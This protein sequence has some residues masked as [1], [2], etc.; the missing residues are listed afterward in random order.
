MKTDGFRAFVRRTLFAGALPAIVL[1][2]LAPPLSAQAEGSGT[3]WKECMD[4]ALLEY[5]DCLMDGGGWFS[6]KL[7]DLAFEIDAVACFAVAAGNIRNA[8]NGQEE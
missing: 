3:R 2:P 1:L 4:D 6:R 8:W 5:N 7:C